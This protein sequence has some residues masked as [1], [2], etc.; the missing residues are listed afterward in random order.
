MKVPFGVNCFAGNAI[1]K[2]NAKILDED[3]KSLE[4]EYKNQIWLNPVGKG[5]TRLEGVLK[6]DDYHNFKTSLD[7]AILRRKM[8]ELQQELDVLE[9][10]NAEIEWFPF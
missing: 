3:C 7:K 2:L 9:G 4:E 5:L 6:M 1:I 8:S 10:T